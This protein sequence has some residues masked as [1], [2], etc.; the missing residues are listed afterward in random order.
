MSRKTSH[1]VRIKLS[2][3]LLFVTSQNDVTDATVC[4]LWCHMAHR[5]VVHRRRQEERSS[6]LCAG[7]RNSLPHLTFGSAAEGSSGWAQKQWHGGQDPVWRSS[8]HQPQRTSHTAAPSEWRTH[9]QTYLYHEC[10]CKKMASIMFTSTCRPM[11]NS[12]LSFL[13]LWL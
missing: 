12:V 6:V 4:A 2:L 11:Q 5:G 8:R 9:S 1:N 3:F 13:S 10:S 7:G